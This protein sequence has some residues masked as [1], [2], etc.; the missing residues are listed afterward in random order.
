VVRHAAGRPVWGLVVL[1]FAAL[2]LVGIAGAGLV[3]EP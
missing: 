3:E 2:L 1:G